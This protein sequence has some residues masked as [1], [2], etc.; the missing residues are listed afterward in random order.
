MKIA[1]GAD[2]A[3]WRR[4]DEVA[5]Q[6]RSLGHE[7]EDFGT[8]SDASC[9]YPDFAVPVARAVA[10]GRCDCG[11]LVCGTG[12]GVSMAANK[13][14]GI[15][16]AA[17]QSVEAVRY[18]RAHNDANVLCVGARLNSPSEIRAMV[19]AWLATAFEGGRHARRVKKI[20]ALDEGKRC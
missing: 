13:V 12:V 7:V 10:A 8:D 16:A 20:N 2:H 3:G 11:V 15:R 14:P 4:K 19:G 17:C 5:G 18:S 1:V 6:L 9:D